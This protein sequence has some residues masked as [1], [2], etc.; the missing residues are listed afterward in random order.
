MIRVVKQ[1]IPLSQFVENIG[2]RV[3]LG[4]TYGRVRL[5]LEVFGTLIREADVILGIMV[6]ATGDQAVVASEA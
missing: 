2:A 6:P 5:E 1:V 3:E 4:Y